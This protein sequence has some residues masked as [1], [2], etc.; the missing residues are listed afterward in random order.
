MKAAPEDAPFSNKEE[1]VLAGFELTPSSAAEL[2]AEAECCYR[3]DPSVRDPGSARLLSFSW[4]LGPRYRNA[5]LAIARSSRPPLMFGRACPRAGRRFP[6]ARISGKSRSRCW[7]SSSLRTA[8]PRRPRDAGSGPVGI[9]G[10]PSRSL[11]SGSGVER[12]LVVRGFRPRPIYRIVLAAGCSCPTPAGWLGGC[13]AC[14]AVGMPRRRGR[15]AR[16]YWEAA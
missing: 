8:A 3:P 15:Q 1:R 11:K 6:F 4:S 9:S 5:T 12:R 10:R 2:R 7:S 16:R 14:C 13:S